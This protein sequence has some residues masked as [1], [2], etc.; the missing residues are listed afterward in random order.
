MRSSRSSSRTSTTRRWKESAWFRCWGGFFC[1][2]YYG[3]GFVCGVEIPK[4]YIF[5]S[6]LSFFKRGG[7]WSEERLRVQRQYVLC[8]DAYVFRFYRITW[9]TP[10]PHPQPHAPATA[11]PPPSPTL[12]PPSPAETQSLR[13]SS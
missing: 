10:H 2:L 13:P 9:C 8:L 1:L 11:A 3:W 6:G 12:S 4:C 5:F 7:R